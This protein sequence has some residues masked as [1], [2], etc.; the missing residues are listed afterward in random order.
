MQSQ[1]ENGNNVLTQQVNP[2]NIE[3]AMQKANELGAVQHSIGD[4]PKKG[5]FIKLHG[6]SFEVKFVDYKRGE[7]RLKILE[8][9]K[10]FPDGSIMKVNKKNM[11]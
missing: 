8:N 2:G 3:A 6:L 11:G 4:L 9:F 7:I 5:D 10:T 1:D